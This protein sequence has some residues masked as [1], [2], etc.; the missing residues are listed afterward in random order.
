[1]DHHESP[2]RHAHA[3]APLLGIAARAASLA[4]SLIRQASQQKQTIEQKG[5]GD[6]VSEVDRAADRAIS[7]LLA[8]V[9]PFPILSEELQPEVP[10]ASS[11]WI[12]DPLDASGAFLV[13]AGPQY[14]AVLIALREDH[15]TV[16]GVAYFPLTNE[17]FYAMRG[18]G[19]WHN[20]K[21]LVCDSQE[22]LGEVWVELNQYGDQRLETDY[23]AQLRARLRSPEGARLVTSNVPHSGVALRIA[24]QQSALAA[25]IH[26]NNPASV[27]QACWDLAPVQVIME[28][29]GGVFLNPEGG[30]TDPFV[31]EPV[32]VARSL[33]LGKEITTM[34]SNPA[35]PG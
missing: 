18:R 11:F 1:M 19:A 7:E 26:D 25:A 17:W 3:I 30:R 27:K 28:E 21:R 20:G 9:T 5:V 16:L 4:G 34:V 35:L 8:D 14:P 31:V 23:F 6:L 15:E 10:D 13:N 29:A 24:L 32:I 33:A 22:R 12:V 2:L